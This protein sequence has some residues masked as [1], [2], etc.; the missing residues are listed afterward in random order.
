[1]RY[2]GSYLPDL[3][4]RSYF[5]LFATSISLRWR[6]N[7]YEHFEY[8]PIATFNKFWKIQAHPLLF[9]IWPIQAKKNKPNFEQV[10]FLVSSICKETWTIVSIFYKTFCKSGQVLTKQKNFNKSAK[11]VKSVTSFFKSKNFSFY[12]IKPVW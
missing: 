9:T 10:I 6:T 12:N 4:L 1:M 7:R 2:W 11:G 3:W 5:S 8:A